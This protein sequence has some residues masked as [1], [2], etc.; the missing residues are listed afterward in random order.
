MKKS[1]RL[2]FELAKKKLRER[3]TTV[4]VSLDYNFFFTVET[5]I[6]EKN[7]EAEKNYQEIW[8]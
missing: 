1:V 7:V 6:T 5:V 2:F 8:N 3:S 4:C